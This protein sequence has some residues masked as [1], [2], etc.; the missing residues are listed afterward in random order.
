M[1]RNIEPLKVGGEPS[2][3]L[4]PNPFFSR[5]ESELSFEGGGG[6]K[7]KNY[8][9]VAYRPGFPLQA[10]ELNEIQE[11]F[12]LQMTLNLNMMN[13]WITSGP[14]PMWYGHDY[15]AP[16]DGVIPEDVGSTI[17]DSGLGL[18]GGVGSGENHNQQYAISGPGWRGST[19]LW[20]FICPYNPSI[21]SIGD[22]LVQASISSGV[23]NIQFNS[24][25]YLTDLPQKN[26]DDGSNS[27][28][29]GLKYWIYLDT[30]FNG[31]VP[32][33]QFSVDLDLSNVL[34]Y[35]IEIPVGLNLSTDY[36]DCHCTETNN[37]DETLG[38]N[39]AGYNNPVACG[40]SRY[41]VNAMSAGTI[42][43]NHW[44]ST[45]GGWTEDAEEEF[46]KLSLVCKV[47]PSRKTVRYMNNII[48]Y[49]W[50]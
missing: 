23:L 24:G 33:P 20:P 37:C 2:F 17:P 42:S 36:V 31:N 27:N 1:A 34:E 15:S 19:P 21:N 44:P 10:S 18:G 43:M 30:A 16:G 12:Q 46:N 29:S 3:P 25:W 22:R 41:S 6:T 9:F 14:G 11:H 38:D 35:D 4:S 26:P 47:N 50:N 45:N 13:N 32:D 7:P 39:A 5:V 8:Q 40:A 28:I 49:D 48:L